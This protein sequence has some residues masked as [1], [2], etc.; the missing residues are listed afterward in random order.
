MVSLILWLL[1]LNTDAVEGRELHGDAAQVL[2]TRQD[3]SEQND[4]L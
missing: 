1:V 4:F 3:M 2:K